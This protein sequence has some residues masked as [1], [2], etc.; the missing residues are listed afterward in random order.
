MSRRRGGCRKGREPRTRKP[1][2]D[3][4]SLEMLISSL[5]EASEDG[6]AM[7]VEGER[8]EKSLRDLGV[9]GP[10]IRAAR[11]PALEV[12]EESAREFDVVIVLTDWDRAGEEL[13][14]KMERHLQGTG[15]RIDLETRERLKRMVR[16]EIKDVES[17]SR[18]VERVRAETYGATKSRIFVPGHPR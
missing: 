15:A 16:R 10:I 3:P 5:V 17:L 2:L 11:R 4:E 1:G 13:A 14:R 18:F 12:A 7:I 9:E 8:D 6:A